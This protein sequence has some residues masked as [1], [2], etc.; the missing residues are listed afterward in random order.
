MFIRKIKTDTTYDIAPAYPTAVNVKE[1]GAVG[2]GKTDDS[3][4]IQSAIDSNNNCTVMFPTGTYLIGSTITIPDRG[5]KIDFGGA[6]LVGTDNTDYILHVNATEILDGNCT[7]I[8]GGVIDGVGV[9]N[10]I[11]LSRYGAIVHD[12]TIAN[13]KEYGI[14]DDGTAVSPQKIIHDIYVIIQHAKYG[15]SEKARTGISITSDYILSNLYIYRC[16]IGIETRGDWNMITNV[17]IWCDASSDSYRTWNYFKMRKGIVMGDGNTIVAKNVYLDD[18]CYGFY[19]KNWSG[20]SIEINVDVTGIFFIVNDNAYTDNP[21]SEAA[22]ILLGRGNYNISVEKMLIKSGLTVMPANGNR[23]LP[24]NL[25]CNYSFLTKSD[26][27]DTELI[28]AFNYLGYKCDFT[29]VSIY[30]SSGG[31]RV[32]GALCNPINEVQMHKLSLSFGQYFYGEYLVK[33]DNATKTVELNK[34][35]IGNENDQITVGLKFGNTVIY[36]GKT[37][38]IFYICA[39][40]KNAALFAK[41]ENLC[42]SAMI[43]LPNT[44]KI[45]NTDAPETTQNGLKE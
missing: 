32:I 35:F 1:Y 22:Y 39:N 10:G 25:N 2:D 27:I 36:D 15:Y 20:D 4:A 28:S 45:I 34:I 38:N 41:L 29:P 40:T 33:C 5:Y 30:D 3:K 24:F 17:H 6:R 37:Y 42:G 7:E 19:N 14:Y 9:S 31:W 13:F 26:N 16:Q 12:M 18:L 23:A 11:K 8:T 21:N 44:R 43:F